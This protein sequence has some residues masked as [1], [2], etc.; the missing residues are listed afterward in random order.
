MTRLS[1]PILG[2]LFTLILPVSIGLADDTTGDHPAEVLDEVITLEISDD[3]TATFKVK[4]RIKNTE[5]KDMD[6]SD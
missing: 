2:L 6:T 4:R 5:K 3:G 1:N